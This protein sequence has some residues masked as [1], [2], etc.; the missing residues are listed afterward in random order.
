MTRPNGDYYICD[1]VDDECPTPK[2]WRTESER[3]NS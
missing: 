3:D 2:K 1:W